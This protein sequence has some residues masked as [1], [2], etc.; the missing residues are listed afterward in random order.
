MEEYCWA[1]T[2]AAWRVCWSRSRFPVCCSSDVNWTALYKDTKAVWKES[3]H[4]WI[5]R[6]P[7]AWALC[8]VAASQ[9][10]PYCASLN[11]HSPVGLVSRQWDA[12]DWACVLRDCR[13]YNDRP[14]GSATS[15]QCACPFYSSRVGLFGKA[16]HHPGLSALLQPRFGSLRLLALTKAKFAFE[17][18]EICECDGHTEHKL[19]Q[20]R[21][22]ADWLAPRESD[23]SRMHSK[24]SSDWLPSYIK[25][26]PPVLEIFK[27]A[28]YFP[29][30]RRI[31]LTLHK[32]SF[33]LGEKFRWRRTIRS[34]TTALSRGV[35]IASYTTLQPG[36]Y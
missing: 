34:V 28:L 19:S 25:A 17:M 26:T 11:S 18:E 27:M 29:D 10:R 23:C 36:R 1:I 13:I 9:R 7:I 12:V 2:Q 35:S 21:L 20:R 16:S 24:V 22:T 3:S 32:L 4:S 8:N 6:E 33:D 15:R 30:S 31:Q 5:S 14:S